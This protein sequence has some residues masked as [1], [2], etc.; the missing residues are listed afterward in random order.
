L[1]LEFRSRF[2]S[3]CEVYGKLSE[4]MHAANADAKLFEESCAKVVDHFDARR[5]YKV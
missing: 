2:P 4:A 3:L 5:V 1:P